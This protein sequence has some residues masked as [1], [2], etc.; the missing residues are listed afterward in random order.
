SNAACFST[1]TTTAQC[2]NGYVCSTLAGVSNVC[3]PQCSLVTSVC[4]LNET[5][6]PDGRCGATQVGPPTI[7]VTS[8]TFPSMTSPDVSESDPI[9][10]TVPSN[11]VSMQVVLDGPQTSDIKI[12]TITGPNGL[13]IF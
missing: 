1:C 3:V 6:F 5:C 4:G 11:G 10:V 9:T 7:G 13:P 12:S 8:M 2:R